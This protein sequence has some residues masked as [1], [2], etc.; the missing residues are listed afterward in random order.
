V[1]YE[2]TTAA[3]GIGSMPGTEPLETAKLI[4]GELPGFP[5]LAELPERGPG[6]DMIG[7]AAALL[8]GMP[9]EVTPRGWKLS[10]HPGR[11]MRRARSMLS[12]D[13]DAMQEALD[14]YAGPLKVQIAGPWTLAATLEQHRSMDR[15]LADPGAVR[16]ISASLAEA[17]VAHLA[18][19][20]RRVP[21]AM[22]VFQLDEP[23]LPAVQQG[24]VPTAS[25]YSVLPAV[26]E[27]LIT[28]RI[29]SILSAARISSATPVYRVVHCCDG[30]P[31]FGIIK[32]AGADAVAADLSQLRRENTA[33]LAEMIDAGLGLFAG[34]PVARRGREP[35]SDAATATA[36]VVADLWHKTG[37]DPRPVVI[38]PPCGLAGESPAG[39]AGELRR[40]RDAARVLGEMMEE[41]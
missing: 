41:L 10:D 25:G 20:A 8:I 7:R 17:A 18:D 11:E 4:A 2:I 12:S 19:V 35:S 36:R 16:D 22:L 33:E 1:R 26:E 38:T 14:G 29:G 24:R 3:T 37:L 30:T 15:A 39:A 32:S 34:V 27:D 13:L 6:A 23:A 31:P 28:E 40:C 21:G 9:V 5:H